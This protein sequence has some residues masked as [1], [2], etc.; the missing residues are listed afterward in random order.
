MPNLSS[1]ELL[2]FF[3]LAGHE[4]VS[5]P[6]GN[7]AS[8]SAREALVFSSVSGAR[9]VLPDSFP[10]SAKDLTKFF[11]AVG[12]Y[13]LAWGV[14]DESEVLNSPRKWAERM[15]G[16]NRSPKYVLPIEIESE[17]DVA[18]W[19]SRIRR[20]PKLSADTLLF[21]IESWKAGAGLEPF[22]EYVASRKFRQLG[23]CVDT[24]VT[25]SANSGTPDLIALQSP[26]LGQIGSIIHGQ[27]SLGY[28]LIELAA[29]S[30]ESA[31]SQKKVTL[32]KAEHELIQALGSRV[33]GEAKTTNVAAGPQLR[34]YLKTG[35]FTSGVE[36]RDNPN[37]PQGENNGALRF[38]RNGLVSLAPGKNLACN[39]EAAEQFC[40][41]IERQ[42]RGYLLL[43]M[44]DER[45][46][47]I[48]SSTHETQ[49]AT[50]GDIILDLTMSLSVSG[51]GQ[52]LR[53]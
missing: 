16:I 18:N 50:G 43:N 8:L 11:G 36:L 46:R 28:V 42:A 15:P 47:E 17:A 19:V 40:A 32:D 38:H 25:I 34:K 6:F 3:E 9:Y 1:I 29:L 4:I 5:L 41:W 53:G 33:V 44:D 7:A 52:L 51:I 14:I 37:V 45:L 10:F 27:N 20:Y 31:E 30:Y 12:A 48:H 35:I 22:L 21:R 2:N 26:E 39:R 49:C 23:Y 24:Q 13:E